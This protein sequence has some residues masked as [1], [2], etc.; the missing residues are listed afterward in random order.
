MQGSSQ[1]PSYPPGSR[2]PGKLQIWI[3]KT[4]A[5]HWAQALPSYQLALLGLW[6]PLV[7]AS[8]PWL[9]PCLSPATASSQDSKAAAQQFGGCQSG[10]APL[11]HSHLQ[12]DAAWLAFPCAL[13]LIHM[14]AFYLWLMFCYEVKKINLFRYVAMLLYASLPYLFP[15]LLKW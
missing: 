1:S 3:S 12:M 6:Y 11:P 2:W 10:A 9:L 15:F 13:F 7:A 8:L 4:S 14:N 5:S